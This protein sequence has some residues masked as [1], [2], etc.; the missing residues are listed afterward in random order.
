MSANQYPLEPDAGPE[1]CAAG[2]EVCDGSSDGAPDAVTAGTPEAG[3]VAAA[4]EGLGDAAEEGVEGT[5]DGGPV[6]APVAA[7]VGG[8][9]AAGTG[10]E[11]GTPFGAGMAEDREAH[12]AVASSRRARFDGILAMPVACFASSISDGACA[13]SDRH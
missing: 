1:G 12:S 5:P 10:V 4:E 7:S 11:P 3:P 2:A 13:P 8:E 6:E 9:L